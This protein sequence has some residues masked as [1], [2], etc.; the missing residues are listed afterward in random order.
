MRALRELPTATKNGIFPI[1]KIRP[2]LNAKSLNKVFD[3]IADAFGD[4]AFGLDLDQTKFDPAAVKPAHQEFARLFDPQNGFEAYYQCVGD[5]TNRIPVVRR[6]EGITPDI[7]EQIAHLQALDRGAVFRLQIGTPGDYLAF[8]QTCIASSMENVVFVVDCGWRMDV[9]GQAAS[10]VTIVNNITNISDDFEIVVAGS[11][12]PSTF[13]DMGG[14]ASF[15]INERFLFQSVR[16]NVNQGKLYYGDWGSTRPPTDPVPMT[17]VPRIDVARRDNWIAW[18]SEDGESYED[19]AA[20]IVDD[21]DWIDTGLWGDYMIAS[22]AA[23]LDPAIR[24]PTMAAAVRVNLHMNAQ[25]TFDEPGGSV[26]EDEP[27]GEDL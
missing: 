12:F 5:G 20:R 2:W 27:V 11:S 9:L 17:N 3:V 19:I 6:N 14:R 16:Q 4:R 23:G 18:R 7:D 15:P 21:Q 25:A 10:C 1:I 24:A 13:A 26:I 22:T 8:A